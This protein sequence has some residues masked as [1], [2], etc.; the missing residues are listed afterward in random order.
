MKCLF[1]AAFCQLI[2]VCAGFGQTHDFYQNVLSDIGNT[3]NTSFVSLR[4]RS[5]A[6]TGRVITPNGY[7]YEVMRRTKGLGPKSYVR[8]LSHILAH[9]G[10]LTLPIEGADYPSH[11][12]RLRGIRSKEM[13]ALKPVARVTQMAAK[14]CDEFVKYYFDQRILRHG[15]DLPE[16]NAVIDQLFRW[17]IASFVS[18]IDGTLT[19]RIQDAD[20]CKKAMQKER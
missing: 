11:L 17:H 20:N 14:G 6:Y 9:D 18:D 3:A 5:S 15:P 10:V 16:R 8:L 12:L 7:L 4:V 2:L 13:I 19:I 1:L